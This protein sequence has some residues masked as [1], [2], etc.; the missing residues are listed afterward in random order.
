MVLFPGLTVASQDEVLVQILLEE[1]AAVF[2]DPLAAEV[3]A[4]PLQGVLAAGHTLW[5]VLHARCTAGLQT[6]IAPHWRQIHC[7]S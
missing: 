7:S 1:L 4:V 2:E 3:F 5:D 6:A